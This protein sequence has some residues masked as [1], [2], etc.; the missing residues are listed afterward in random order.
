[1]LSYT[2]AVASHPT[3]KESRKKIAT[4]I[5]RNKTKKVI[6]YLGGVHPSTP[7]ENKFSNKTN[8]FVRYEKDECQTPKN[9]CS[10]I[11][12]NEGNLKVSE[13]NEKTKGIFFN[14]DFF[15]TFKFL[16]RF[17]QNLP[18]YLWLDFC[19]MPTPELLYDLYEVVFNG[20]SVN[21][22]KDVYITF[23]LN[24]RNRTDVAEYITKYGYGI[25]D[26]AKSLVE[27]IKNIYT[28]DESPFNFS[29]EIFDTYYNDRAP[30]CVLKFKNLM[31]TKTKT[32]KTMKAPKT[33]APKNKTKK[34]MQDYVTLSKRFTNKQIAI[35]WR[36]GT[37]Q[38]AGY[39]ASAKRCGLIPVTTI[40]A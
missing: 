6:H 16:E 21:T 33:T 19:G 38:I 28:T 24:P 11:L 29:C 30:M 4:D 5:K 40:N 1:M 35:F 22:I 17:E 20:N 10:L 9:Y 37:M 2:K 13:S 34:T 15:T 39:E 3:K 8:Y 14:N 26:R 36:M 12:D 7:F 27:H 23:F 32:T 31:K 18:Q 25:E